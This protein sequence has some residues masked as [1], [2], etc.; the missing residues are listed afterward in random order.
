MTELKGASKLGG[1]FGWSLALLLDVA[2]RRR[3]EES[4]VLACE[5]GRIAVSHII[6]GTSGVKAFA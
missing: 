1:V 2:P 6:T 3:T 4:L 5:L